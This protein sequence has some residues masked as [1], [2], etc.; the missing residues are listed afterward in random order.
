MLAPEV[1]SL[2][3]TTTALFC[4]A[5]VEMVGVAVACGGPVP[6]HPSTGQPPW[7]LPPHPAMITIPRASSMGQSERVVENG[8]AFIPASCFTAPFAMVVP[9]PPV[10][11]RPFTN[12]LRC[13]VG[14]EAK[15]DGAR[16]LW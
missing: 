3:V 6:T 4:A 1:V 11:L 16:C 8:L 14:V 7:L 13:G 15:T 9:E 12:V 5:V 2:M 10:L